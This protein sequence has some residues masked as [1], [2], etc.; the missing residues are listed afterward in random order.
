MAEPDA[1]NNAPVGTRNN[2]FSI[3]P[4]TVSLTQSPTPGPKGLIKDPWPSITLQGHGEAIRATEN[5]FVLEFRNE[6][7]GVGPGMLARYE[8]M[9]TGGGGAEFKKRVIDAAYKARVDPGLLAA[10]CLFEQGSTYFWTRKTGEGSTYKAGSDHFY[11]RRYNI[12]RAAPAASSIRILK[13][14]EGTNEQGN[15]VK[16]AIVPANQLVLVTACYLKERIMVMRR[17][18]NSEGGQFDML[19]KYMQFFLSRLIFNPGRIS[20]RQRSR[21]IL[22]GKN[23]IVTRGSR[24]SDRPR[25]GA[26][27]CAA[28][29]IQLNLKHFSH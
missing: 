11:T 20:L 5:L 27:I 29:A 16:I 3:D 28:L 8:K 19:P 4:G 25:R 1:T 22:G 2:Q 15:P 10:V 21:Q 6:I 24:R 13:T 14:K 12:R 17:I 18:Y 7:L 23:L 26:T 9:L